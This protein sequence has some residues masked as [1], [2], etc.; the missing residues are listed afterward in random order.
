MLTWR[1]P[2]RRCA[3]RAGRAGGARV[4]RLQTVD[5]R[6]RVHAGACGLYGPAVGL[7][8]ARGT[9]TLAPGRR[10]R[11]TPRTACDRAARSRSRPLALLGHSMGSGAVMSAAIRDPDRYAATIAVSPTGADV[12]PDAPRDLLLQAGSLEG[13]F[14][15][16]AQKL[17]AQ[18]GGERGNFAA[19]RARRLTASP[20]PNTSLSS[21]AAKPSG[22]LDWLANAFGEPR[23]T[24]Y[25]DRRII[26]YGLSL[27]GWLLA[28]I[29]LAPVLRPAVPEQAPGLRWLSWVACRSRR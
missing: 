1:R 9:R 18:G 11:S 14:A 6:L 23:V 21:S 10:P 25:V 16:N 8:R 15:G 12:T 2:V 13:R 22:A 7:R 27:L 3:Q 26:W 5:A 20:T 29:A 19:G 24:A 28:L 4:R 17:L